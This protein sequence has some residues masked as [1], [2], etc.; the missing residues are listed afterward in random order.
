MVVSRL[1]KVPERSCPSTA[2]VPGQGRGENPGAARG[3]GEAALC[4]LWE[5]GARSAPRL[6]TATPKGTGRRSHALSQ[7]CSLWCQPLAFASGV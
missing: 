3:E 4:L 7:D 5:A 1:R 2:A 6:L